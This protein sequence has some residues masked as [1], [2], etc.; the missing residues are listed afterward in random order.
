MLRYLLFALLTLN[1]A[2]DI[3]EC[4]GNSHCN[5]YVNDRVKESDAY[6]SVHNFFNTGLHEVGQNHANQWN[7]IET[8]NDPFVNFYH[9]NNNVNN[10]N[11]NNNINRL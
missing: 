10:N 2:S 11:N 5:Q 9:P 6:K 4:H 3:K 8:K 7:N 1:V